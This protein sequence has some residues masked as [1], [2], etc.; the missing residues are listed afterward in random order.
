MSN[1]N[2]EGTSNATF[3]AADRYQAAESTTNNSGD[4]ADGMTDQKNEFESP[5]A[6]DALSTKEGNET[7][8]KESSLP[9]NNQQSHVKGV[10]P[11]VLVEE[12]SEN[13]A[14]E[15]YISSPEQQRGM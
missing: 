5:T 15:K 14:W 1:L 11:P 10:E 4:S 7:K 2:K 9:E 8:G 12:R 3:Y 13:P 6:N